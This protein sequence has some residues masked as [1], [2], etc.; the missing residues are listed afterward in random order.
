MR[1]LFPICWFVGG[2]CFC[3]GARCLPD[4][5]FCCDD[6]TGVLRCFSRRR[7]PHAVAIHDRMLW[8]AVPCFTH[9]SERTWLSP[10]R[11]CIPIRRLRGPNQTPRRF[12]DS[13]LAGVSLTARHGMMTTMVP[14]RVP[15]TARFQ[16]VLGGRARVFAHT[17]NL[18]SM[19]RTVLQL[20]ACEAARFPRLWF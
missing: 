3:G 14:T 13:S 17:C 5:L 19:V 16:G 20:F 12:G 6:A 1:A 10:W 2:S 8:D 9:N 18:T 4:N 15:M 11:A 7:H